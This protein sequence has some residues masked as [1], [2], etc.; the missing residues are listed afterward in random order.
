MR[1]CQNRQRAF[2]KLGSYKA[3]ALFM[4]MGARKIEVALEFIKSQQFKIDYII[5]IAP[6]AFLSTKSYKNEI[7]KW[8]QGLERKI[9]FYSI[10]SLSSSN[11][12]YFDLINI[13][14]KFRTFCVVDEAITIKNTE[15]GRTQRLLTIAKRFKFR[16]L[17]SGMPIT[18]GLLDLYTQIMFMNPKILNMSKSQFSNKFL[19]AHYEPDKTRRMLSSAEKEQYLIKL[20]RP[21]ILESDLEFDCLISHHNFSFPLTKK[22]AEY[23]QIEK[24]KF[25]THK[26]KL[27][28]LEIVQKFQHIYTI[29]KEKTLTMVQLVNEI[30]QRG[31]KVIVFIKFVDEL[32]FLKECG[33][34]NFE[35]VE[36]TGSTNRNKV[37]DAFANDIQVMFST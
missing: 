30:I 8:S 20:M 2:D 26:D 31:E 16:L 1:L 19:Q 21:Y 22:E 14:D 23:Y 13:I 15:A 7:K 37:A 12:K 24:E 29:S 36:M 11:D 10:E 3:G 4:K 5:W 34:L 9:Y 35:Y 27:V 17:L 25:L 18:Q 33:V 32:R 6:A 28:F